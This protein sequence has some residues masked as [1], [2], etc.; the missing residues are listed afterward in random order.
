MLRFG[1]TINNE[2]NKTHKVNNSMD[3]NTT[4]TPEIEPK[5]TKISGWRKKQIQNSVENDYM[6]TNFVP[7]L[8]SHFIDTVSES[9]TVTRCSNG[10]YVEQNG[11]SVDDSWHSIKIVCTSVENLNEV[12]NDILL[13]PLKD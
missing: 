4:E 3:D 2:I 9:F 1:I 8:V 6:N 13:M 12:I 7:H 5:V 11:R 10:F